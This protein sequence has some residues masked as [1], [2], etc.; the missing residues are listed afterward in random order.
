MVVIQV[1]D[2]RDVVS[3]APKETPVAPVAVYDDEGE[4]DDDELADD[5][6]ELADDKEWEYYDV[7]KDG[8]EIVGKDKPLG[9]R[10]GGGQDESIEQ[11]LANARSMLVSTNADTNEGKGFP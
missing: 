11:L 3:G 4:D 7:D 5:N 8:N 2:I 6:K 9:G 10:G 1:R